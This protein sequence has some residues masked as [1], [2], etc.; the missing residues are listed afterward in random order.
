MALT[1][2]LSAIG[3]AIRE[4]TGKTALL[5]L[6]AMPLE[7]ASIETGGGGEELPEEA[8]IITDDCNYRFSNNGWNWFI[9]QY[10][11]KITTQ[12][13]NSAN[14]MFSHS[15]ALT[16]IPFDINLE[17]G[18]TLIIGALTGLFSYCSGLE[19]VPLVIGDLP[20]PS[21]P[22]SG[23][24]NLDYIFMNCNR[25]REI[26]DDYFWN[27]AGEAY[28]NKAQ[29]FTAGSRSSLFNGCHSLRR[30]P[31]ISMLK[32]KVSL[33][34]CLYDYA[35]QNCYALDE[36]IDLP[37][38]EVEFTSNAFNA[39]FSG[40][41]RVK[42]ITFETN[43]DGS[44]QTAKWKNQTIDL[45]NS[46]GATLA[47]YITNYNSG[48]TADKEAKDEATYQAVKND[49]DWFASTSFCSRYNHDSAVETINSLP[50]T[51]A[52]GTNTI[53]FQRQAGQWTDGGAINTLTE[54][55]IAV[56]AAKG[57]T[58]TLV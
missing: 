4:K 37:V 36:I 24:L 2:K 22:Y 7:I 1:N 14:Y 28:W 10:G 35:F 33:Y 51:S 50:D 18:T 12:N 13:I 57:W 19:E 43:E 54:E 30:L 9:N 26:P 44:P 52:Y 45:T 48:I 55:E 56:A 49:P 47:Y 46:V 32:N 29:E 38:L 42:S 25:V 5:T 40:C 58:V 53:K 21:G 39:T 17:K 41:G 20:V 3:D 23:N 11:N 27:I 31:D 6:D 8:F 15:N 34:M 16:H